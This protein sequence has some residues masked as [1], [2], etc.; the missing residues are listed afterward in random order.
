[1]EDEVVDRNIILNRMCNKQ[2]LSGSGQG[3][4]V[5][6]RERHNEL[7]AFKTR[8]KFLEQPRECYFLKQDSAARCLLA[9]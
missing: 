4:V 3:E 6:P 8:G 9:G 2:E 7:G 5:G 1:M